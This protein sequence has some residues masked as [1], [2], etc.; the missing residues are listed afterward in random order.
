M[1]TGTCT[2]YEDIPGSGVSN[3]FVVYNILWFTTALKSSFS[4][5]IYYII[6][7]AVSEPTVVFTAAATSHQDVEAKERDVFD[8]ELTTVGGGYDSD[9][10]EFICPLDGYYMFTI[11]LMSQRGEAVFGVVSVE[12][13]HGPRALGDGRIG[14]DYVH[15]T[16]IY[17]T[18][19]SQ[20]QKVWVENISGTSYL[21]ADNYSSF[22]GMLVRAAPAPADTTGH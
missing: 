1:T 3:I 10:S 17:F 6:F 16:T 9:S 18:H 2:T 12:G 8:N 22:S 15:A 7:L 21:H 4:K 5:T 13:V 20:G 14:G 19:C 11:S